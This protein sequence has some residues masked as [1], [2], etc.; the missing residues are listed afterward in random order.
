MASNLELAIGLSLFADNFLRAIA[1]TSRKTNEFKSVVE[2]VGKVSSFEESVRKV[3]KLIRETEEAKSGFEKLRDTIKKTFDPNNLNSFGE[4]LESLTVKLGTIGGAITLGFKSIVTDATEFEKGL[5]EA[6][7]LVKTDFEKFKKLYSN[8]LL[9]ISTELGQ[10]KTAVTKAFYDAI[11][12]GFDPKKALEIIKV[13]GKSAV[14]GVSDISTA[15]NTLITVMKA[16]GI[17]LKESSDYIF[18]TIAKGRTTK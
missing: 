2:S 14:A 12:S 10:E 1:E 3:K 15:N 11:S 16:W 4:K 13:A 17:D 6:S 7:T 8:Q 18:K 5:A 9:E